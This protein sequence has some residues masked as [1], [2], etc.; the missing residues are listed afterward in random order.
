[1]PADLDLTKHGPQ[2][3]TVESYSGLIFATFSDTG[4]H[5]ERP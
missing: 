3:V 2:K 1:M 4:Q 5:R